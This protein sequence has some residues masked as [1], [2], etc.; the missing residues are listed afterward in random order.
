MP[1]VYAP[2]PKKIAWPNE[3]RPVYPKRMSNPRAK[4]ANMSISVAREGV[5]VMKGRAI[6]KAAMQQKNRQ[7]RRFP[8]TLPSLY[9][10]NFALPKKPLGLTSRI[11]AM[12]TKTSVLATGGQKTTPR[13]ISS[14][15]IRPPMIEPTIEPMPPMITTTNV[16]VRM[17][18][19][20]SGVTFCTGAASTPASP[21]SPAPIPKTRVNTFDMSM[22]RAETIS[23]SSVPALMIG[24]DLR[25]GKKKPDGER[26]DGGDQD[27][28]KPVLG[29]EH[30][31]QVHRAGQSRR[32]AEGLAYGREDH[33]YPLFEKEHKAE[34]QKEVVEMGDRIE[35]PDEGRFDDHADD[36][37]GKRRDDEGEPEILRVDVAECIRGVSAEHVERPVGKVDHAQH[38]EDDGK[39]QGQKHVERARAS[40]R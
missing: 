28:E 2:M 27:D 4:M 38:A 8:F 7:P 10:K 21:A 23:L 34:R 9:S 25:P 39:A 17:L 19:P 36:A 22:P 15:M 6:R 24:A 29:K 16:S 31:A 3:R 13:V 26:A 11:T 35:P 18:L 37:H 12:K 5:G 33:P 32:G 1:V 20:I 30:E 40:G 14:P